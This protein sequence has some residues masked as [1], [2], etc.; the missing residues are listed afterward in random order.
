VPW[1]SAR[2]CPRPGCGRLIRGRARLC[3]VHEAERQKQV[4]ALRPSPAK[5]GYDRAWRDKRSAFL[6][7]NYICSGCGGEATEVDHVIPLRQGG[8]DELSNWSAKCKSC[9][10]RKTAKQSAFR[11]R[12]NTR[13]GG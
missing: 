6:S 12:T 8:A 5:R 7:F 1:L 13:P 3:Q 10:S 2:P 11:P 9:H 4:D